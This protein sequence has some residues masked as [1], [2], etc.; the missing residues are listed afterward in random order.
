MGR[1]KKLR[2]CQEFLGSRLFKP[3][4][5]PL[6]QIETV[7]IFLDEL[8]AMRLCDLEGYDQARAAEEMRVSRGTLQRL[9]YSARSKMIDA[10]IYGKALSIEEAEHVIVQGVGGRPRGRHGRGMGRG[11]AA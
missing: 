5:I 3:S 10:V 11:R 7:P 2:Y 4:G 1:Y 6:S 8:E 9:V